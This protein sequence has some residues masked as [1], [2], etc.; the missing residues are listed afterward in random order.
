MLL[1]SLQTIK[2]NP[3][4]FRISQKRG[5]QYGHGPDR[6]VMRIRNMMDVR[7]NLMYYT[8]LQSNMFYI[9]CHTK[10]T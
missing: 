3:G 6:I 4:S 8:V 10:L 7:D 1:A 9:T 2:P 5:V